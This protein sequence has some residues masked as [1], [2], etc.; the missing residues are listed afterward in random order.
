MYLTTVMYRMVGILSFLGLGGVRRIRGVR[1][2]FSGGGGG[3]VVSKLDRL[4]DQSMI[5]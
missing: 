5:Q 3:G 4:T 2:S 1:I